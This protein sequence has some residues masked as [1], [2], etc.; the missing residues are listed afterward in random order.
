MHFLP[1]QKSRQILPRIVPAS[2]WSG[3]HYEPLSIR[4]PFGFS[5]TLSKIQHLAPDM[6]PLPQSS[7][8]PL[9]SSAPFFLSTSC[10][11][12]LPLFCACLAHRQRVRSDCSMLSRSPDS[13][14]RAVERLPL[15]FVATSP[16][17]RPASSADFLAVVD[18][19]SYAA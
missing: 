18:S 14:A 13:E 15:S 1:P 6:P 19:C 7:A 17:H 4:Q 9:V 10:C 8:V 12:R 5:V 16:K 3:S 2:V 11:Y